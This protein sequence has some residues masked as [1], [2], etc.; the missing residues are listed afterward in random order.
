MGLIYEIEHPEVQKYE[1]GELNKPF[2]VHTCTSITSGQRNGTTVIFHNKIG[3]SYHQSIISQVNKSSVNFRCKFRE[4]KA[5]HKMKI[6]LQCI[7]VKENGMK[8]G[9][10]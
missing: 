7:M 6:D 9:Q 10:A 5:T 2:L 4:C 8:R 3:N 1:F